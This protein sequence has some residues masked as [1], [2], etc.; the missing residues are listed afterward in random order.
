L[1]IASAAAI[2]MGWVC[3]MTRPSWSPERKTPRSR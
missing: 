1:N 2:F 3:T